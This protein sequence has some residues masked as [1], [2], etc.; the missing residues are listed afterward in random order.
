M[1]HYPGATHASEADESIWALFARTI[2]LEI[3]RGD[4]IE[5]EGGRSAEQAVEEIRVESI[6]NAIP[7]AMAIETKVMTVRAMMTQSE[8]T[9]AN[10]AIISQIDT[11][12][13]GKQG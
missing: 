9:M 8:V 3:V 4:P 10:L 12:S 1:K 11:K 7:V 6:V 2:G 13:S 5:R